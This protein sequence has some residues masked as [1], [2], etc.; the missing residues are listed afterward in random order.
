MPIHETSN[1]I[2][3]VITTII[4]ALVGAILGAVS[5]IQ[6]VHFHYQ[7]RV[8]TVEAETRKLSKEMQEHKQQSEKVID[9]IKASN[10]AIFSEIKHLIERSEQRQEAL[11]VEVKQLCVAT[12]VLTEK[13]QKDERNK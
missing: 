9:E 13:L 7:R 12:A 1:V 10:G 5:G 4:S 6:Y 3:Q 8:T 2:A 11:V